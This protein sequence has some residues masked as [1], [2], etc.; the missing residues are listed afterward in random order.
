MPVVAASGGVLASRRKLA[1]RGRR[2]CERL[3]KSARYGELSVLIGLSNVYL[4]SRK[5]MEERRIPEDAPDFISGS[6][7]HLLEWREVQALLESPGAESVGLPPTG[8]YNLA[9]LE[10]LVPL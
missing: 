7:I 6:G 1:S 4:S 2:S 8:Q 9:T 5:P 3:L 10:W